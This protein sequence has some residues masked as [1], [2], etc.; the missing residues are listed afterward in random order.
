M[1]YEASVLKI[2]I[3]SPSDVPVERQ[4]VR[5]VV[6]EWNAIHSEDRGTVLL[7]VG[8]E[9]HASPALGAHP[10]QIINKQVLKGCDLLIAVFWTKLGT[11]TP[12]SPSGTAEE[13]NEHIG[14]GKPALIYFSSEPVVMD[15]VDLDEYKRLKEFERDLRS[16]GLLEYYDTKSEFREK[17][18]RQL[19]QTIIR[20]F[21]RSADTPI[22]R[23][24]SVLT[25][26]TR[27]SVT[28][29]AKELLLEAAKDRDGIIMRVQYLGGSEVQTNGRQFI[30]PQ[31]AR[32]IAKWRG[33]VDELNDLG[34]VEDRGGKG[35]IYYLTGDGFRAA[36]HL[37]SS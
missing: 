21:A 2:M 1:A 3:A 26:Q 27:I 9:T 31:D 22:L 18:T 6:H 13:I 15:S 16:R 19:A 20:D 30:Q 23:A 34:F 29:A 37:M 32:T 10:Q 33:A 36:D 8:W 14:E 35:E 25:E 4:L 28:P 5:D 7:P 24:A 17:I 11:P 12:H